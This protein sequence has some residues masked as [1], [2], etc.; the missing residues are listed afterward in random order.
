[1]LRDTSNT[2][3]ALSLMEPSPDHGPKT[4]LLQMWPFETTNLSRHSSIAR[5][6]SRDRMWVV[7]GTTS[8]LMPKRFRK[9][10]TPANCFWSQSRDTTRQG[11]K[12]S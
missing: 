6:R 8:K 7:S 12:P 5:S 3:S 4:M 1:M 10:H 2:V 11:G 9:N